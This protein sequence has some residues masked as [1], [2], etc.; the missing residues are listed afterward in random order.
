MPTSSRPGRL[1]G[2]FAQA[3]EKVDSR[4]RQTAPVVRLARMDTGVLRAYLRFRGAVEAGIGPEAADLYGGIVTAVAERDGDLARLVASGLP[5]QLARVPPQLRPLYAQLLREVLAVRLEALP[6]LMRTLPDLVGAMEEEALRPFVAQGVVL[7]RES[8]HK[9]ESFLRRESKVGQA[10][11][12]ALRTGTQLTDVQRTLTLYA[13]AHCG[14]DVQVRPGRGQVFSDGHHVYLPEEV[15]RFGDERDFLVYKVQTALAAGYI[16]FGTFD[17]D[18]QNVEGK[19]PQ[20]TEGETEIERFLRAFPTRT[21]ARDLFQ[22]LEDARVEA[23][24]R[25]TYPGVGRDIRR[26]GPELRGERTQPAAPAARAVEALARRAWGVESF[27]LSAREERAVAPVTEALGRLDTLTVDQVAD[28]VARA[29]PAVEGLM[30]HVD[31]EPPPLPPGSDQGQQA[32]NRRQRDERN[33]QHAEPRERQPEYPGLDSTPLQPRIAPEQA[34]NDDRRR[35]EEVQRVLDQMR[36][37]GEDA[38]R[39]EARR[40]AREEQ[41]HAADIERD[42]ELAGQAPG[43]AVVERGQLKEDTVLPPTAEGQALDADVERAGRT[44]LYREWDATIEDYKP[45][46]VRV[47]EARLKEGSRTFV[48][49]VMARQRPAIDQLRRRFEALRPQGLVRVRNLPDGDDLDIDRVIE[50]HVAIRAGQEPGDRVYLKRHRE[51]RDVAVAF[52]LDMSSSTNE[53]ADGSSR[54]II[55]VEKEALIVAAE[56]LDVLGDPFAV[57]GFSGYGREH[58]M[59]Y[60]AKSFEDGWDDRA[61][62]RIGRMTFKME[63]RDGAAIRHATAKLAA[64]PA[65]QRLLIL[66]SD[67]KPLDCG[68]DHY[69]DRYAQ[70]DTRV[71]LR[72]ARQLGIHPF[73]ITVDPS[74]PQ[75]LANMYGEVAYTV[76]DR[77]EALPDRLVKVY[78]RLAL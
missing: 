40:R 15:D 26:L 64:W 54:K 10:A 35:E 67:G 43:G 19:W 22:L 23:R 59:F 76:I 74:G 56:A 45:G 32:R 69:F 57:W 77:V 44:F 9:A 34:Q 66:L 1:R 11:A 5:D 4:L 30:R 14:E 61:R 68:C 48:D 2:L 28:A 78:R 27:P 16:E 33:A 47:R 75:Y 20:R 52:L 73:C 21:L 46:W 62:E 13:R 38:D 71:A 41:R 37:Q 58:V 60:E 39:S 25:A 3:V 72:E 18:L 17:L 50:R 7:H 63:N 36:A 31:D 8:H 55:E 24:I 70:E 51:H 29:Y 6:L 53:S 65:R 12:R 42:A 49:G